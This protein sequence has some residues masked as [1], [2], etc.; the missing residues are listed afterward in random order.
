ME[1]TEVCPHCQNYV[2]GKPNYSSEQQAVRQ[3]TKTSINWG[4]KSLIVV[5]ITGFCAIFGFGIG[6]IPGF[7]GSLIV[8]CFFGNSATE[9]A[10]SVADSLYESTEYVFNCPKCG[11][12]WRHTL[13]NSLDTD[14][15]ELL[16]NLQNKKAEDLKSDAFG[17]LCSTIISA[18]VFIGSL[19]YWNTHS[20][21]DSFFT[22]IFLL[23]AGGA[24]I[25]TAVS[26]FICLGS[27]FSKDSAA[28]EVQNMTVDEFRKS[29]YRF[30]S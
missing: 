23:G 12:S 5:G 22:G 21:Q 16:L 25:F 3:V 18:L 24:I 7:I 26:F 13:K 30:D 6:A 9:G 11:H 20:F 1:K 28:K 4:L 17:N 15:D 8:A 27:Y 2:V 29:K 10:D 14:S 19:W